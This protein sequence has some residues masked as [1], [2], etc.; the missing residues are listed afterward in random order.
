[1]YPAWQ[2]AMTQEFEALYAN[3]T[4]DLVPLPKGKQVIDCRWVYKVK[5]TTDSSIERYKNRLVV[6]GCT[7]QAGIDYTDTFSP[8]VKMTT[9]RSLIA[10]AAK[11]RWQIYQLY[12]NN[13]FLHGDLYEEV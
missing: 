10:I 12:V 5:H 2:N 1:M 3:S 6:K 7:Q 13:A 11:K 9:V 4:W 8:V